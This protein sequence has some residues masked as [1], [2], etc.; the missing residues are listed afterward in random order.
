VDR[1]HE[2]ENLGRSLA[3]LPPGSPSGL[4]TEEGMALYREVQALELRLR[5]IKDGLEALL[6]ETGGR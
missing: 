6:E 1:F 2:I 3:T 4:S 5:R